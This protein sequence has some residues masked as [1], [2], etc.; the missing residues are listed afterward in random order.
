MSGEIRALTIAREAR[1]RGAPRE[2]FS[3][4][5]DAHFLWRI[6]AA[7]NRLKGL[8]AIQQR[9]ERT[10][11]TVEDLAH[12]ENQIAKLLTDAQLVLI[13]QALPEEKKTCDGS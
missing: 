2:S 8:L 10:A 1:R 6:N 9:G 4:T 11:A 3:Q 12:V 5:T 13:H 7:L